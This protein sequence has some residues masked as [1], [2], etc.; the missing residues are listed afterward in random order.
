EGEGRVGLAQVVLVEDEVLGQIGLFP[1]DQPA[2][3]GV[4]EPELVAGDVDRADLLEPEVPFRFRVEEGPDEAAARPVD[5]EWHV[6]APV[7]LEVD[8]ELVNADDVVGV[9]GEGRAENRGDAD[10]VLVD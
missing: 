9:T 6:E 7:P 5:V 1:E 8:E 3:A 4:D 2:D 10:R